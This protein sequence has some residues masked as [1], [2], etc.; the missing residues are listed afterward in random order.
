MKRQWKNNTPFQVAEGPP[1]V[2]TKYGGFP[3]QVLNANKVEGGSEAFTLLAWC[4]GERKAWMAALRAQGMPGISN[5]QVAM[6]MLIDTGAVEI[7]GASLKRKDVPKSVLVDI[8]DIFTLM[9]SS[10]N[11]TKFTSAFHD[12]LREWADALVDIVLLSGDDDAS[13][14]AAICIASLVSCS[15]P[16]RKYLSREDIVRCLILCVCRSFPSVLDSSSVSFLLSHFFFLISFVSFL[17]SV[18]WYPCWKILPQ[19]SQQ[20][21]FT[22]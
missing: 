13:A 22:P 14:A 16:L 12:R 20:Q 18:C 3:F 15:S 6:H 4:E 5:V 10:P 11:V 19:T 7:L 21:P 1:S 17:F 9:L 8:A 2:Q